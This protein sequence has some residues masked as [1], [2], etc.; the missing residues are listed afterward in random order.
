M[1]HKIKQFIGSIFFHP[2]FYYLWMSVAVL[3]FFGY[4]NN[5]F[6]AIGKYAFML[7]V[8]ATLF[9]FVYLFYGGAII[10]E[11]KL[12]EKLSN[13]DQNVITVDLMNQYSTRMHLT[14]IDEL[15]KQFQKRDFKMQ[16]TLKP[17]DRITK[18]YTLRPVERGIY[19]FDNLNVFINSPIRLAMVRKKYSRHKEVKVYPSFIQMRKYEL[20]ALANKSHLGV[21]KIRRLGHTMEFEQ[22]KTYNK[23]DDFRTINWKATAKHNK[24]MVNQYQ[25]E[26][27]QSIYSIIDMGRTMQMPFNEMSLLDY[28]INSTLAFS[29]IAM[30]KKDKAG[31]ISFEKRIQTYLKPENKRKHLQNIFEALYSVNTAFNETDYER[32]YTFIRHNIPTRSML[33]VY[34]NFEHIN[35]LKRQL[36]FLKKLAKKHLVVVIIFENSELVNLIDKKVSDT[37]TLYHKIIANDFYLQ[38]RMMVKELKL[39]NIQTILTPPEHLTSAAINKYL[40]LKSR[41][42]I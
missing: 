27:S 10:A 24:L 7:L 25:D 41:G 36:P 35:S 16:F 15:P 9:D 37:Q 31:L 4:W 23:G 29:N 39:H 32:L 20:I 22:I 34:T 13:G 2:N 28:A 3:L 30:K 19:K 6:F 12:P 33:M 5:W 8:A 11:R 18:K 26:K 14:I 1:F 17:H 42:M 21:K 38:K 40:Q